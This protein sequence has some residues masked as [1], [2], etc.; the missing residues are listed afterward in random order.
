VKINYKEVQEAVEFFGLI[1]LENKKDI[2][3][4]YLKLSKFYHPDTTNGDEIKFQELNKYYKI[5]EKYIDN[6]QFRFT[7]D[8][9]IDQYPLS[10]VG[11]NKMYGVI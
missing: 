3:K 10:Y 6:F 2:K 8:E 11:D 1:G 7:K 5:L 9:F 4:K